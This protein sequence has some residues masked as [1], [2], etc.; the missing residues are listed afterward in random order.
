MI[1][2]CIAFVF[3][4]KDVFRE[5]QVQDLPTMNQ[6]EKKDLY[7]NKD[8]EFYR[9]YQSMKGDITISGD[10]VAD[11]DHLKSISLYFGNPMPE[12]SSGTITLK[13]TDG[14]GNVLGETEM[15]AMAIA[16]QV[17]TTYTFG[18]GAGGKGNWILASGG[19]GE[20]EDL[21]LKEGETYRVTLTGK[22]VKSDGEF[23]VVLFGYYNK[24]SGTATING[25]KVKDCSLWLMMNYRYMNSRPMYLCLAILLLALIFV[26]IPVSAIQRRLSRRR[27]EKGK[28]EYPIHRLLLYGM[29]LLTPLV[30]FG[31]SYIIT[32]VHYNEIWHKLTETNSGPW[33]FFLILLVWWLLYTLTNRVKYSVI[34]TTLVS[35]L[36]AITNYILILFRD[37]PLIA[38]DILS[39]RTGFAVM[40][41]YH[42]VFDRPSV[43]IIVIGVAWIAMAISLN[44]W[45]GPKLRYRLIP[46]IIL[47]IGCGAFYHQI[48][49]TDYLEDKHIYVNGFK[50]RLTYAKFGYPLSFVMTV[51]ASFVE[52][53]DGYSAGNVKLTMDQFTSDQ[54]PEGK[55]I[56]KETPNIIGIM[57][58]SYSDLSFLGD[59]RTNEDP[60]PFYHSLTENTIKGAMHS[61]V[62]GSMTANSEFEFL[63]GF[64]GAFLPFRAI[65]YNNMVKEDTPSMTWN[66]KDNGYGGN[67]AFHPGLRSSYNRDNVYPRLGFDAHIGIEDLDEPE[68]IRAF[69]S[70]QKDYEIVEEEY[71]KFRKSAGKQ[72]FYMFNVTIQNH[73]G[74]LRSAG[75]VDAG[76]DI[77]DSRA[78]TEEARQF[79]NL[80]K[81]SD[82]A[83]EKLIG[84][85]SEVEE[86]T[87]I[88][89]FGD[90]QPHL[91][92]KFYKA[93]M[94]KKSKELTPQ[95]AEGKY[96]VP[97]MIW[98][99][100]DIEEEEGVEISAN[101]LFSY[102][103]QKIGGRLTAFD[104]YLL[105]LRET[106]PVLTSQGYYDS[107]G[108]FYDLEDEEAPFSDKVKEYEMIQYNGLVDSRH[109]VN[110]FFRL[111][112]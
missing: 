58:E 21:V 24:T 103:Q 80:M 95:E 35:V 67:I 98:A 77:E 11:T 93:V 1:L 50:P 109:R 73:G 97:F 3:V 56:T 61:S 51:K 63:T 64:S 52:K 43:Y 60:I 104:K 4:Q 8:G 30:C 40:G 111:E 55:K 81:E 92:G 100:Y 99:N 57:N 10:F 94:G 66:L 22:D 25:D 70:D 39:A 110:E 27:T 29:F 105:D 85:F 65:A 31:I 69:V 42:M 79:L 71:E 53:P 38:A 91:E 17:R 72:P 15:N 78:D 16:N 48:F 96:R 59:L 36:F 107:D 7:R 108:N 54:K 26:W 75:V 76:I 32:G 20:T 82:L 6:S 9:Y 101:Y 12:T 62:Y 13:V 90:H 84:Y 37:I 83:L 102:A 49:Q 47:V 46:V 34:L 87:V 86:P 5:E 14:D 45:K 19:K 18:K 74:Y 2:I 23:Y 41:S 89:L 112:E 106:I 28:S 44:S 68:Q 88:I 33:N